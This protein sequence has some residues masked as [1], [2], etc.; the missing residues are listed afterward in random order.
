[1]KGDV[2]VNTGSTYSCCHGNM[3]VVV[4]VREAKVCDE[5][6]EMKVQ[7]E[8]HSSEALRRACSAYGTEHF[9]TIPLSQAI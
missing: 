7:V 9:S 5:F 2:K 8:G 1:M 3:L 4:K 6:W